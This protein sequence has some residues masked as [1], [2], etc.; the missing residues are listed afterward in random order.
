MSPKDSAYNATKDRLVAELQTAREE[1]KRIKT[2][3]NVASAQIEPDHPDGAGVLT[4]AT[5]EYDS[6]MN[7]YHTAVNTFADFVLSHNC[8]EQ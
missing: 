2:N 5:A 3:L 6:A 4:I 8:P 1:L 7:H